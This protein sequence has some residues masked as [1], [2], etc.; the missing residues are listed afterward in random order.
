MSTRWY[1]LYHRSNPQLRIFLPNFWMKMIRPEHAQPENV[2][3]F[4]VSMEMTKFDVKNY[5]TE[6]YKVPVVEVRT[7]IAAGKSKQHPNFRYVVKN[8]D[9]K[10]AYVTL[11]SNI[12]IIQI[13]IMKISEYIPFN[14]IHSFMYFHFYCYFLL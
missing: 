5:L 3:N 9:V 8:D 7:R 1:P 12:S 11:V 6:I 14:F 10:I 4:A 13:I 2:V